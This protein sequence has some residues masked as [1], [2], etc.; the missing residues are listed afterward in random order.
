MG[1]TPPSKPK[2]PRKKRVPGSPRGRRAVKIGYAH[3]GHAANQWEVRRELPKTHDGML[4]RD[5]IKRDY[6]AGPHLRVRDWL[7]ENGY[8]RSGMLSLPYN[9]WQ[10][11]YAQTKIQGQ[12]EAFFIQALDFRQHTIKYKVDAATGNLQAANAL[13]YCV[14]ALLQK[15]VSDIQWDQRHAQEIATQSLP[16]R[17]TAPPETFV[18]LGAALATASRIEREWVTTLRVPYVDE[19]APRVGAGIDPDLADVSKQGSDTTIEV[20]GLMPPGHVLTKEEMLAE[21][22]RWFDTPGHGHAPE[23]PLG[24]EGEQGGGPIPRDPDAVL[25]REEE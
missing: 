1:P 15:H 2:R 14:S 4:D 5:R 16:R 12:D 8:P 21:M 3:D 23:M 13:R 7:R 20:P 10:R 24:S 11:E 6:M 25:P 19:L 22:T 18:Q 9:A 17:F